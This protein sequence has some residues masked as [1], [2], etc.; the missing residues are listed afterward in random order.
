MV[1][2][3][4]LSLKWKLLS[5]FGS[6]GF[7]ILG[8]GLFGN[9]TVSRLNREI[10]FVGHEQL[11]AVENSLNLSKLLSEVSREMKILVNP[12]SS[13]VDRESALV[14]IS[15]IQKVHKEVST[16]LHGLMENPQEQAILDAYLD[17]FAMMEEANSA[18]VERNNALVELDILNPTELM[19]KLEGFKGDHYLAIT[20]AIQHA[21]D[22]QPFSGGTDHTQCRYGQWLLDYDGSNEVIQYAILKSARPHRDFHVCM[23]II[24]G[25]LRNGEQAAAKQEVV[26]RLVTLSDSVIGHFD[27]IISEIQTAESAYHEMVRINNEQA[28]VEEAVAVEKLKRLTS[29]RMKDSDEHVSKTIRFA[30][31]MEQSTIIVIAVCLIGAVSIGFG[32][33]NR[34]SKSLKNITRRIN[35]AASATLSASSQF[36]ASSSFFAEGASEQAASLEQTSASME[37]L[38]SMVKHNTELAAATMDQAEGANCAVRE[39]IQSITGLRSGVDAVGNSA[40]EL[41]EA[42]DAIHESSDNIS[43]IMK[44]IDGIAFQTN[45]LA[46]N[47]AVEAARAGDAGSGFAVVAEEVRRLAQRAAEAARQTQAIIEDSVRRSERGVIV[48]R[49]VNERLKDVL[50]QAGIVDE[51]LLSISDRG[52]M[53]KKSMDDLKTSSDEQLDGIMQINSAVSHVSQVT[54][55]NAANAHEAANGSRELSTQGRELTAVVDQ[56][57]SLID[58]HNQ[59]GQASERP[60]TQ[61]E[62]SVPRQL[63]EEGFETAGNSRNGGSVQR[64]K[65]GPHRI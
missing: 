24:Q 29:A 49:D 1:Q 27:D 35:S 28:S 37:Q 23:D 2:I 48:N 14:R 8:L 16:A 46:L 31:R 12:E 47:A 36:A 3:P 40:K 54:Q 6:L 41:S 56:L 30:G 63:G 42:M 51:C 58:G 18:I 44:S 5:A 7:I 21:E 10:Q 64:V 61:Q 19:G 43:S 26:K 22:N 60:V 25:Q 11:Y 45:I 57:T 65:F 50:K 34:L 62:V 13:K 55:S 38:T 32:Y 33:G 39:G 4:A 9:W 20:R 52:A 15:E 59:L 17:A 53:V